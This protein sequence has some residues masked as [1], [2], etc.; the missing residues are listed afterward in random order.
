MYNEHRTNFRL[1][2]VAKTLKRNPSHV[3]RTEQHI[4]RIEILLR[5]YIL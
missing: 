2:E 3:N 1:V 4:N 5:F